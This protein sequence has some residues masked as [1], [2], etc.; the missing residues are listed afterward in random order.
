MNVVVLR[1][2]LSR[3][4]STRVL[5]SGDQLVTYEVTVRS[6]E[7][8]RAETVPV[9]WFEAPPA[10]ADLAVDDE[11]VVCGRVRRRFF[12]AGGSTQSRVEVVAARVIPARQARTAQRLVR[13]ACAA[14]EAAVG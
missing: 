5:P 3:P 14:A 10:A 11:V 9:S 6:E 12:R 7:G 2:S 1:G 4:P 8:E 13:E